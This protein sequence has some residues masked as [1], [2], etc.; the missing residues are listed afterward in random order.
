MPPKRAAHDDSKSESASSK[1]K[2]GHGHGHGAG[3]HHT[4]GKL[5]RVGSSTGSNLKDV[6]NAANLPTPPAAPPAAPKPVTPSIQWST[7]DREFLHNYRRAYRLDTP[8]A[9][10]ND[11]HAWILSKPGS[12]GLH[13]PTLTSKK[14][15]RRQTKAQLAS[16]V[17]KHF[18]GQGIQENDLIVDFL[19]KVRRDAVTK[20]ST[21]RRS[22]KVGAEADK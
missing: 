11:Y 21:T 8:T 22:D 15:Y 1:D 16:A 20:P 19:H 6:T 9:Y 14:E 5:R 18:N 13:S 17:R 7:F 4:N 2:N 12:F 10:S 3:S